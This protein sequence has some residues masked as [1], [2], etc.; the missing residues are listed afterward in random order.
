[1]KETPPTKTREETAETT[2]TSPATTGKKERRAQGILLFPDRRGV[3]VRLLRAGAAGEPGHSG[4]GRRRHGARHVAGLFAA[5]L[6]RLL[7]PLRPAP[8]HHHVPHLLG[9]MGNDAV[10]RPVVHLLQ[11]HYV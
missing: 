1:M 8:Q 4:Y 10:H 11:L 6:F 2:K 3:P 5:H 9:R 7:D